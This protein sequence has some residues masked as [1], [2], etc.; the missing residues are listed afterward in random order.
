[1]WRRRQAGVRS[2]QTA[3][4]KQLAAGRNQLII[5][6]FAEAYEA[7]PMK[8]CSNYISVFQYTLFIIFRDKSLPLRDDCLCH[9]FME[10]PFRYCK[11]VCWIFFCSSTSSFCNITRYRDIRTTHPRDKS[12]PFFSRKIFCGFIYVFAEENGLFPNAEILICRGHAGMGKNKHENYTE[13]HSMVRIMYIKKRNLFFCQ[14]FT[15]I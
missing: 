1:M 10:W 5:N 9:N 15:C 13:E 7:K 12:E 2:Q 6:S 11:E 8:H 3:S 14:S 4:G